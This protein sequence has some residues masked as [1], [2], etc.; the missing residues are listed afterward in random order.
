MHLGRVV[1]A[2]LPVGSML[3]LK[4]TTRGLAARRERW[5]RRCFLGVTAA[6]DPSRFGAFA[7]LVPPGTKTFVHEWHYMLVG[8]FLN[9]LCDGTVVAEE[10]LRERRRVFGHIVRRHV[11][12]EEP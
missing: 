6:T 4:Q 10:R 3:W 7:I 9:E 8:D 5:T 11:R 12:E 2:Y 1:L